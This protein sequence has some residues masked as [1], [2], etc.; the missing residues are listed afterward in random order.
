MAN[1]NKV[2]AYLSGNEPFVVDPV[3]IALNTKP[4]KAI[5]N[6][7]IMVVREDGSPCAPNEHG[8]LVHRGSLVAQGYWNDPEKT[9]ERFYKAS[10]G[11][12]PFLLTTK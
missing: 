5:P 6:A 2:F 11:L 7:E 4:P 1:N 3:E 9:A 10:L 8:E 12:F